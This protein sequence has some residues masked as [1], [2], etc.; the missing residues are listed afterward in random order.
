MKKR[1]NRTGFA[2]GE[3]LV[4][5]RKE[6]GWR[7]QDFAKEFSKFNENRREYGISVVSSWEQNYRAPTMH[8]L[9][10]LADFYDVSLD[11]LFGRSD[12]R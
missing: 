9:V 5:L 8:T 1:R 11:Y 2:L 7:Q 12:E 10:S 6:R 4:F 3:K